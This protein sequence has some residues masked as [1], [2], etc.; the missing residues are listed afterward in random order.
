MPPIT[1][2]AG[3]S[4]LTYESIFDLNR[5]PANLIVIGAGPSGVELAQAFARLGSTVTVIDQRSSVL[6]DADPDAAATMRHRLEAEGV[7][8]LMSAAVP[9]APL[10]HGP[11]AV[12][13]AHSHPH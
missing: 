7:K 2:L 11:A 4:Y 12:Q 3:V 6:P 9:P 8:G 5:L 1:G 13:L 10:H